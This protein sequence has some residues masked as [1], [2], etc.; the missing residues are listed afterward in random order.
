MKKLQL[1]DVLIIKENNSRTPIKV[2]VLEVTKE[3]YV[4][5]NLDAP[6]ESELSYPTHKEII[7]E[8]TITEIFKQF[9]NIPIAIVNKDET[10]R[11][12]IRFR[13]EI[14]EFEHSYKIVEEMP[15]YKLNLEALMSAKKEIYEEEAKKFEETRNKLKP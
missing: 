15:E 6:K 7:I 3:T 4:L 11:N 14:S 1:G 10:K 9:K 13:M 12:F 5:A 8:Q 2:E